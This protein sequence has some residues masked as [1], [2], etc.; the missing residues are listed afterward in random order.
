MNTFT[1]G[2]RIAAWSRLQEEYN[3]LG[4]YCPRT[5]P[6]LHGELSHKL[7]VDERDH[8]VYAE[9]F[10]PYDT[11]E[12]IG[13]DKCKDDAG[14]VFYLDDMLR[15]TG[16]VASAHFDFCDFASAYCL[17][18]PFCPP[19]TTDEAT[20]CV[21][22]FCEFVK[23]ELPEHYS[24]AGRLREL[25][26]ENQ[27][28]VRRLYPTLPVSC[29]Q[30]DLNYSNILIDNG[31]FKGVIDF[32][33]AGREPVL[34]YVTRLAINYSTENCLHDE[35]GHEL[36]FFDER[37][38]AIRCASILKNLGVI[39]ETYSFSTAEREAFPILFRYMNSFWWE[40]I[41]TLKI[42][43]GDSEKIGLLFSWLERQMTRDD[44]RLP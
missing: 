39:G 5:I 35:N 12:T 26:F 36:Y 22:K 41:G 21:E 15:A 4:I 31:K 18:E 2:G 40:H 14:R 24:R 42:I 29:F 10:A 33:L 19:D 43:K 8:Y 27:A 38:D 44:L 16:R 1:D 28:A 7:T 11:V 9:E 17:L 37:L 25:F 30:A 13:Y 3:R 20:E 32:N 34:N 23:N 6:N